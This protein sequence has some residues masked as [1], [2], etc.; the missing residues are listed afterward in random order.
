MKIFCQLF[1]VGEVTPPIAQKQ[2]EKFE[3]FREP[4]ITNFTEAD[5]IAVIQCFVHR[6]NILLDCGGTCFVRASSGDIASSP[7]QNQYI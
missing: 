3:K 7:I 1:F 5:K 6:I 2:L 4:N